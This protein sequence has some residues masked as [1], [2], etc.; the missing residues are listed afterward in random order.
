[1]RVRSESGPTS[2]IGI[3]MSSRPL[4]KLLM[5]WAPRSASGPSKSQSISAISG[6]SERSSASADGAGVGEGAGD[7]GGDGDGGG[8][9]QSVRT[10]M[11]LSSCV[12]RK[13]RSVLS[14]SESSD[15]EM[16]A[17]KGCQK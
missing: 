6:D 9:A 13:G 7:G 11:R 12:L 14:T 17:M 8:G 16:A 3:S 4:S 10:G 2:P 15:E 5:V 1:M